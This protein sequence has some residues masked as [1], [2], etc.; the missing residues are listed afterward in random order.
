M[1]GG[2]GGLIENEAFFCKEGRVVTL[3]QIGLAC[4]DQSSTL[5]NDS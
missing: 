3:Q 1:G 5:Y 4:A 2:G